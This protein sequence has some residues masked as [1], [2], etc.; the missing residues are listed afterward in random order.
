MKEKKSNFWEYIGWAT[1]IIFGSICVFMFCILVFGD[2]KTKYSN[3]NDVPVQVEQSNTN[4][5]DNNSPKISKEEFDS[6]QNGMS[7]E[8]VIGIIGGDGELLSETGTKGQQFHTLMYSWEGEKGF[9]S[10]ANAT[11]QDGKLINKAQFGLK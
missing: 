5:K 1:F 2:P 6:I 9:G 11:F 8:E 3:L 10:N 7:Y 4:K